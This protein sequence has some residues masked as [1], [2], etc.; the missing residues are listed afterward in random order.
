M[1]N[2]D[3]N[4]L[5]PAVVLLFAVSIIFSVLINGLLLKF[6]SNLGVR[7]LPEGTIRWSS[8]QKPALGGISFFIIFLFSVIVALYLGKKSGTQNIELLALI[9]T[10]TIAFLM[11]L[12]DDAYNTQPFLKFII[13]FICA[14]ILI[15]SGIEINVFEIDIVNKI[16]TIFWVIGIMNSINML[17]N[18]DAITSVVSMTIFLNSILLNL[19]FGEFTNPFFLILLGL[20]GGILGFLFF[21]WNPSKMYMG[22]TG[23]QLLGLILAFIGIKIFWNGQFETGYHDT[24][25]H[26]FMTLIAFILPISDTTTVFINRIRRKQSPF[27]GGRDHT[28]HHLSY[29]GF[30]DAQVAF[31]FL[32]VSFISVVLVLIINAYIPLW[33]T[34]HSLL[35]GLYIILV[36][37]TLY[38]ITLYNKKT[39]NYD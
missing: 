10:G 31:I 25:R 29:L 27:K 11:G 12:A 28:T 18:M 7:D 36:F 3:T 2:L 6:S 8:Q 20:I 5:I 14:L 19:Y 17:D 21:N 9:A 22:D 15:A 33:K 13:Q 32:F 35:F 39:K 38:S 1:I 24:T 30:N 23:S 16:I 26:V 34:S 37:S 4:L